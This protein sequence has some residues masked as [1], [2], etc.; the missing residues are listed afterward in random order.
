MNHTCHARGCSVPVPE[1]MLMCLRHWRMVPRE[2]KA[3]VWMHYRPKQEILKD[4]TPKYLEAARAAIQAV[5]EREENA[6]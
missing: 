2:L 4:P 1:K 6:D 5:A 3:G